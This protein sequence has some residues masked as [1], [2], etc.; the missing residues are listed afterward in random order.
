MLTTYY[1][2]DIV[3]QPKKENSKNSIC[4]EHDEIYELHPQ[5]TVLIMMIHLFFTDTACPTI[6]FT[7]PETY[8]TSPL[9]IDGWKMKCPFRPIFKGELLVSGR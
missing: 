9:R 7:L 1:F 5:I 2:H 6:N 8:I 4:L 3:L